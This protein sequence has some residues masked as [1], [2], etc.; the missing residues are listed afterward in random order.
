MIQAKLKEILENDQFYA[1]SHVFFFVMAIAPLSA[2]HP[3]ISS[4]ANLSVT[5]QRRPR[6]DLNTETDAMTNLATGTFTG[7]T[8]R[9]HRQSGSH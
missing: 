6:W 8:R 9:I 4:A 1:N 7:S 5:Q 3:R 2:Y